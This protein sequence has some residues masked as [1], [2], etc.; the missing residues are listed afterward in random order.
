MS[1]DFY[2]EGFQTYLQGGQPLCPYRLNSE[3][4]NKWVRG[5]YTARYGDM[6]SKQ[7]AFY[8]KP[9]A[10]KEI[11]LIIMEETTLV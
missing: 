9:K 10:V 11:D 5:Y 3:R 8:E 2:K 7:R 6:M 1:N 4:W